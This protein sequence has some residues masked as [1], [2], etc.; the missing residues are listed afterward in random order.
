VKIIV[1]IATITWYKFWMAKEHNH[2]SL[3]PCPD[4]RCPFF[5]GPDM[6]VEVMP[7]PEPFHMKIY[8]F[9]NPRIPYVLHTNRFY[10]ESK[11]D[12]DVISGDTRYYWE[13]KNN[14]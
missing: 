9:K 5:A 8:D 4:P 14:S 1:A 13:R 11:C 12:M 10:Y 3:R 7:S 6:V 2:V